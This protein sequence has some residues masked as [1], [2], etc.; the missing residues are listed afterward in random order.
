MPRWKDV[1]PLAITIGTLLVFFFL[2]KDLGPALVL[3]CVFLGLYGVSRG[4]PRSCCA[5]SR[6]SPRGF[7][8]GYLLGVPGTVTRRVAIWLDP[9]ENALP[10]GDQIA[11]ALWALSSGGAWGLAPGRRSSAHS[12]WPHGPRD[13]RARRGARLRGRRVLALCCAARVAD[14]A[15]RAARPGDYTFFLATGLTLALAVQA[16]VIV[17]GML[18]LLP[19]AGVVTPFLSYGRSAMFSNFAAVAVCAAIARRAGPRREAFVQ[20]MRDLGW[21]LAAA[22]IMLVCRAGAGA[23]RPRRQRG[24]AGQ[25]HAAGRWRLRYQYNPRLVAAGRRITRGTIYDRT[26]LP[27]ATSRPEE[28]APFAT[29]S[30]RSAARHMP[31]DGRRAAIRSAAWHS[32]SSAIPIGRSTGRRGTRRSRS[33][34]STRSS[35]ASTIALEPSTCAIRTTSRVIRAV[36]RDY[37]ELLRSSGTR[38][39]PITPT[40][41]AS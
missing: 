36:R 14:A 20:P 35:R 15:Y 32:T 40:C 23:G 16:I 18:G 33:R 4:R 13:G 1:R 27:L 29:S 9:W 2:Q 28:L 5:G 21:T 26:G 39:T 19:L 3:S 10:G 34:I 41:A 22:A 24:H 31:D 37:S 7:A 8:A 12:G 30:G 17:G 6:R 25:A 38:A 11:H